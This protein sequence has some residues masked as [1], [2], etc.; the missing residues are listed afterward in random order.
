[1]WVYHINSNFSN[2]SWPMLL[3]KVLNIVLLNG[4]FLFENIFQTRA[5][6]SAWD[7]DGRSKFL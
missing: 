1:M 6:K 2:D 5:F 7:S 3:P 4:H